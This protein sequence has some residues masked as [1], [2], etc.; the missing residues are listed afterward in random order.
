MIKE[1]NWIALSMDPE[2][3]LN[4]TMQEYCAKNDI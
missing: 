1:L 4:V 3:Q 2:N